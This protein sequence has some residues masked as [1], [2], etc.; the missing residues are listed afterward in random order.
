MRPVFRL[1]LAVVCCTALF[2]RPAAAGGARRTVLGVVSQTDRGHLDNEDA[3]LGAN[4]YSCDPLDTNTGGEMRARIGPN[5]IYL[6]PMSAAELEGDGTEI[7]ILAEA[8]TVAFSEPSSG[9]IAVRT[10]AGT[11]RAEGAMAVAGQVTYKGANELI[12]SAL[13]GNLTLDNGGELRTIPEGKSA[14]VTFADA[15][16]ERCHEAGA[17]DEPQTGPHKIGFAWIAAPLAGIPIYFLWR[18]LTESQSKPK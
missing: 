1:C 6:A 8:G 5:Q 17:A 2:P 11:I 13:H 7:Q 4:I 9:N 12:I 3:Q 14:D 10:P 16:A 18:D 15:L